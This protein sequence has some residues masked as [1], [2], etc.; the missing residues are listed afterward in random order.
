MSNMSKFYHK[1]RRTQTMVGIFTMVILVALVGGYAWL[2]DS[3]NLRT[4]KELKVH[5]T[6][7]NGL[8]IGD[9]VVFRGMEIGR[10]KK[11]KV[12]DQRVIIGSRVDAGL[13]IPR[14]SH[15]SVR[16]GSLMG[17][18]YLAI[19]AGVS[20]TP[21]DFSIIHEGYVTPGI[22]AV[23]AKTVGSIDEVH[24]ILKQLRRPGGILDGTKSVIATADGVLS[25][26]DLTRKE[27]ET[28]IKAMIRQI[29]Q[30]TSTVNTVI[31]SNYE[32]VTRTFSSAPE[33][34]GNIN[35][36]LDSL[37]TLAGRLNI[38]AQNLQ[39]ERNTAGKLLTDDKLYNELNLT[40]DNLNTLI[41][42]IRTNPK[43]YVR[44]S[45]F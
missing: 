38:T 13:M 19:D 45:L 6:D 17:G 36:T 5:F 42:D 20:H 7:V 22:M 30:L 16:E 43:K 9:K 29:D 12:V 37:Q 28:D 8:E 4:Q 3:I 1:I 21:I 32:D 40:L 10:I 31:M 27:L 11:V 2:R 35:A 18:K 14:D 24:A 34:I 26:I 15:F 25:N 23:M 39:D 44:F 41:T 33:L